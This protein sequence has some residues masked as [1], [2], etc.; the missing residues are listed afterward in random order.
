[1]P[2]YGTKKLLAAMA[3]QQY[4]STKDEQK[5]PA[6]FASGELPRFSGEPGNIR[7]APG[8]NDRREVLMRKRP[9][10]LQLQLGR[11][12]AHP[13]RARLTVYGIVS[14]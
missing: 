2:G 4:R 10:P 9:P 8:S 13:G 12:R 5:S 3:K 11:T 6:G 14:N 1:M 7:V